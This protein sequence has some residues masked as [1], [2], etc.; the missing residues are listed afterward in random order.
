MADKNGPSSNAS[1]AR[2]WIQ[3]FRASH[4]ALMTLVAGLPTEQLDAPSY[5]KGW[6]VSQVLSHIGSGA[7]IGLT[8]LERSLVGEPQLGGDD[9][10]VIWGRWNALAPRQK[11]VE[12]MTWDRRHVSV[13]EGLDDVTASTVRVELGGME[14]DLAGIIGFRVSEHAVHSWDVAV[15]FE[16]SAELLNE[17]VVLLLNLLPVIVQWAGK[18]EASGVS[19]Q[20][21]VTTLRPEGHFLLDLGQ[22]ASLQEMDRPGPGSGASAASVGADVSELEL[23][24]AA[25]VRLVAGRLDPE[26]TPPDVK[27]DG[28]IGVEELRRAFPGL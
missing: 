11:A 12:M 3:A 13:V 23:P 8:N 20:V 5:C 2:R 21:R 17:P 6:D 22:K 26:H 7:E 27:S 18:P 24:A 1:Q 15:A 16:P 19:G 14:L 28:K 9:F 10:P 4:N 25:L